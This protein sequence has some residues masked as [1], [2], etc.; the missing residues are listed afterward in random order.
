MKHVSCE[1]FISVFPLNMFHVISLTD[2]PIKLVICDK[3]IRAFPLTLF[4]VTGLCE[5]PY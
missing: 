5:F 2:F 3:F 4:Y 1:M